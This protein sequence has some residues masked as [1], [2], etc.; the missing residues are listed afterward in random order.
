ML[1]WDLRFQRAQQHHDTR[2]ASA[3]Q[4]KYRYLI[5]FDLDRKPQCVY[6]WSRETERE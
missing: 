3:V 1:L 2:A 4:Q 5:T 6:V